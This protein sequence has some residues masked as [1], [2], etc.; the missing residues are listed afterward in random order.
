MK[1]SSPDINHSRLIAPTLLIG[2]LIT[3]GVLSGCSSN[4]ATAGSPAGKPTRG[5]VEHQALYAAIPA[6]DRAMPSPQAD[7]TPLYA[8]IPA[9]TPSPTSLYPDIPT[10][11]T[12]KPTPSPRVTASASKI[13]IKATVESPAPRASKKATNAKLAIQPNTKIAHLA[14]KPAA[15]KAAYF[16]G[17]APPIPFSEI[18]PLDPDSHPTVTQCYSPTGHKG[19]DIAAP[20]GT[21]VYAATSGIA[22]ILPD[23]KGY[24]PNYV[25]I[26]YSDEFKTG[27]GHMEVTYVHNGE[28]L[29][30][31]ELIGLVGS[32]G[33]STGPHLHYNEDVG[34][35][36]SSYKSNISPRNGLQ[37]PPGFYMPAN[38]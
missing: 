17:V 12:E 29:N 38:C 11:P 3:A 21:K 23:P 19:I 36:A 6:V 35:G 28:R 24:G 13:A 37:L 27:Y 22:S 18:F 2:G 16:F 10:R 1:Y 4:E 32:M 7:E 34:V 25:S 31:G 9:P 30:A 20:Y 14:A 33:D 5:A 8:A 26:K 15:K